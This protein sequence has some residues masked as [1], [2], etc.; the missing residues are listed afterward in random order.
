MKSPARMPEMITTGNLQRGGGA[1]FLDI[2]ITLPY[3]F[4]LPEVSG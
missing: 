1:N 3:L 4:C 2:R